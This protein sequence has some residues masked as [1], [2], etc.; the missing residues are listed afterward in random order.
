MTCYI[1]FSW[2]T[3]DILTYYLSNF[4]A[5]ANKVTKPGSDKFTGDRII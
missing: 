2:L 5:V 3:L 4:L 1:F